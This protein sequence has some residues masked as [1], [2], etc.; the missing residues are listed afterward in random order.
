MS[1]HEGVPIGTPGQRLEVLQNSTMQMVVFAVELSTRVSEQDLWTESVHLFGSRSA[2]RHSTVAMMTIA[3][4]KTHTASGRHLTVVE[5]SVFLSAA[6]LSSRRPL[7]PIYRGPQ[8]TQQQILINVS[9]S[10]GVRR[11]TLASH[12]SPACDGQFTAWRLWVYANQ[13]AGLTRQSVSI[14]PLLAHRP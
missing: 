3:A 13:T 12:Q 4:A 5:R 10:V 9:D 11:S 6:A 1:F 2:D 7:V 8:T 14:R